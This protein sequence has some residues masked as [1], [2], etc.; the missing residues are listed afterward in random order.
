MKKSLS[1]GCACAPDQLTFD[2]YEWCQLTKLDG[3]PI[4]NMHALVRALI[5]AGSGQEHVELDFKANDWSR[6]YVAVNLAEEIRT[7]TVILEQHMVSS[8]SAP[9]PCRRKGGAAGA[10]TRRN[11]NEGHC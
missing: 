9:H 7:R 11:S 2:I 5:R 10:T 8:W 6:N 4:P 3:E 1:S